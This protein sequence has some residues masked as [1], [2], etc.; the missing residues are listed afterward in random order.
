MTDEWKPLGGGLFQLYREAEATP[1][2][3][4]VDRSLSRADQLEQLG[5]AISWVPEQVIVATAEQVVAGG[6]EVPAMPGSIA[7]GRV[8]A[9]TPA[10]LTVLLSPGDAAGPHPLRPYLW[11]VLDANGE[12][13]LDAGE[14]V[15]DT[16]WIHP[17][18]DMQYGAQTHIHL[19]SQRIA[20]TGILRLPSSVKGDYKLSL[21]LISPS[22]MDGFAA[23]KALSRIGQDKGR[24][25]VKHVR[26]EWLTSVSC[27]TTTTTKKKLFGGVGPTK[28]SKWFQ[29]QIHHPDGRRVVDLWRFRDREPGKHS[30]L[31]A[32][33]RASEFQNRLEQACRA[34]GLGWQH[35]ESTVRDIRDGTEAKDVWVL[36]AAGSHSVPMSLLSAGG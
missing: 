4:F 20:T 8:L 15:M 28:V 9:P 32:V 5:H 1:L 34:L 26:F 33:Q 31:D 16:E 25:W 10:K 3:S 13:V 24:R 22:L 30:D 17:P 2:T 29:G 11:P 19:T 21:G 7:A 14:T 27:L 12:L 35:T 36:D 18:P 23:I 6:Y